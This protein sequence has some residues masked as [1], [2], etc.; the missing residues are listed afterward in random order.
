MN[1]QSIRCFTL[2][3]DLLKFEDVIREAFGAIKYLLEPNK[4]G[5]VSR[6]FL[7]QV[8]FMN[9][10]P[11]ALKIALGSFRFFRKFAEIFESQGAPPVSTTP[12]ANFPPVSTTPMANFCH[13]FR[14]CC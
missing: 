6:D 5:T 7:L 10:L 4:K 11:Q 12:V 9:H 3:D 14:L 13:Q 8:F 2:H 1:V